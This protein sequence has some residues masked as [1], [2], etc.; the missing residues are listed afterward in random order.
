MHAQAQGATI[1]GR[2]HIDCTL[3][4]YIP[5]SFYVA[6]S[7]AT[8]LANVT[9]SNFRAEGRSY[10]KALQFYDGTYVCPES[11]ILAQIRAR[12][13]EPIEVNFAADEA[14]EPPPR[15]KKRAR[16]FFAG[17]RRER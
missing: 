17:M 8:D 1:S 11:P 9:L 5:A 15:P 2:V 7:R 10:A 3:M 6:M 16:N 13:D 12:V 14:P 4:D